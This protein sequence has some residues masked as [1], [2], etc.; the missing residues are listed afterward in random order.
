MAAARICGIA[1]GFA[2]FFDGPEAS[3]PTAAGQAARPAAAATGDAVLL[4]VAEMGRAD[5]MA[6]AAGTP[7]EVLMEAAGAAVASE[8]R[9]RWR[10]CP[11]VVLCGPGNNG[12]DGFV[13]ARHLEDAGWD[14]VVALLGSA[15]KLKGD[16]A[17]N[18][19]RWKGE[20]MPLAPAVLDGRA[21]VVDAI[22]G[23]GLARPLAGQALATIEAVNGEAV[24]GRELPCV[25][26]DTPSGID[27]DSGEVR[28]AAPQ[29][30]LTVTFFRKKPGHLLLPGRRLAGEV[31]VA[32]IGIAESVLEAIGPETVE[33][34]PSLWRHLLPWPRPE[35]HK[36]SRG[37]VIVGGGAEMTGA[38]RLAAGAALRAG[39][40]LVT[41]A[42]PPEVVPIYAVYMPGVLT[43]P[44]DDEEAFAALLA[45]RRKNAV[46]LGPGYGVNEATRSR[47]LAALGA[48]KRLVLDADA[49]TVFADK[50]GDL[51]A[52]IAGEC[53]LTPHEG[54]FARIFPDLG[55]EFGG[56]LARARQAAEVSGAVVLLKGADTVIASP[57]GRA[58]INTN[59]PAALA[60]GGAGDVLAGLIIGLMA[61]GMAPFEAASAAAWIHGEAAFD[62][63]PGLIAEDLA[64]LVPGV[65]ARL[66]EGTG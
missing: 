29:C 26:V 4:T 34:T 37:H 50:P 30:A 32:D 6:I 45:D 55:G 7:G 36:Y 59:A 42:S 10:P 65:L 54:E 21:L 18:A 31:V 12:G 5:A 8:I 1:L 20:V 46:L 62:F 51:F 41:I 33:N 23:A 44:V 22:F 56:K 64:G 24:N 11:T 16:A 47:V 27:G 61:Q 13:I 9:S 28:G 49:L 3:V 52:A 57:G 48:G 53:V 60:T 43:I 58:A 15:D 66:D 2:D 25:G 63:G 38:A 40:G 17:L 35:D 14:V 19:R 39:A